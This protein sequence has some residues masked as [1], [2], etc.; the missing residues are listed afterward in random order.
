MARTQEELTED[1]LKLLKEKK[2]VIRKIFTNWFFDNKD[3]EIIPEEF[4]LLKSDVEGIHMFTT[5]KFFFTHPH[6]L[7]FINR[8][9]NNLFGSKEYKNFY[10]EIKFFKRLIQNQRLYQSQLYNP[11]FIPNTFKTFKDTFP[12][13]DQLTISNMHFNL[14]KELNDCFK[15]TEINKKEE[16][17]L[18]KETNSE[19][20]E[21]IN[22][23]LHL[24]KTTKNKDMYLKE[25]NQDIIDKERLTVFDVKKINGRE[26]VFIFIN[27][28]NK[29]VFYKENINMHFFI[30]KERVIINNDYIMDLS[31]NFY[32]VHVDNFNLLNKVRM[33]IT[34]NYQK[35][36]NF[37]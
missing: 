28:E 9:T 37:L 24:V 10:E 12:K 35:N 26:V 2:K 7:P 25:L 23:L 11:R 15:F 20:L 31:D 18:S 36:I 6:I 4:Y 1:E 16:T 13:E 29:K 30:S 17:V 33:E 34:N 8:N 21:N 19:G 5:R 32:C 27:K 14:L 3:P 22:K